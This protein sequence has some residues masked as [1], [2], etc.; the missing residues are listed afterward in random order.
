MEGRAL[1]PSTGLGSRPALQSAGPP[2][3]P[4]HLGAALIPGS[5]AELPCV[6]FTDRKLRLEGWACGEATKRTR[7]VRD[8][9]GSQPPAARP[10]SRPST[11]LCLET[12]KQGGHRPRRSLPGLSPEHRQGRKTQVLL[13]VGPMSRHPIG[14][15][16]PCQLRWPGLS[17]VPELCTRW[18][19]A[20]HAVTG[21]RGRRAVQEGRTSGPCHPTP[22]GW[23][24]HTRAP[25]LSPPVC[26][27]GQSLHFGPGDVPVSQ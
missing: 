1:G 11:W 25:L 12:P 21:A 17:K 20:A 6:H 4:G 15:V 27:E 14:L 5:N 26:Y 9:A 16:S 7:Q 10:P 19:V 23:R 22:S 2:G 18:Q 24:T 13:V 3:A 8:G